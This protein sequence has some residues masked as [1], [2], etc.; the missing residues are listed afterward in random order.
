[1]DNSKLTTLTAFNALV[2]ELT[3]LVNEMKA[4]PPE[5]RTV[6]VMERFRERHKNIAE[7]IARLTLSGK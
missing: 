2:E 1:M 7:R 6:E 3:A 4:T 5:A